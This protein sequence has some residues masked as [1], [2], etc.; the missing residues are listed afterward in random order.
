VSAKTPTA[1]NS[2]AITAIAELRA[3]DF[4]LINL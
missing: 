3:K 4:F 2:V 1:K